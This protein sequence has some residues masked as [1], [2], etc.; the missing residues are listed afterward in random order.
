MRSFPTFYFFNFLLHIGAWFI[1]NDVSA[2]GTQQSDSNIH[3]RVPILFQ[4]LFPFRLLNNIEQSSLS[5]T[6]GPCWLSFL[7]TA[8]VF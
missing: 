6:I 4:I 2:S 3:T 7:N 5:Y 8:V 1:N